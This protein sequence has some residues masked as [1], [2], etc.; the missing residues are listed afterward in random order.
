MPGQ[1]L[2]EYPPHHGRGVRARFEAVG[3]APPCGVRF[4]RV[5]PRI[6]KPVSVRRTAAQVAALL[7]G[8]GGHRG[9]DP[10][11]GPGDLPLGRQPQHRHGVLVVLGREVDP[12]ASLRHPQLDA[13]MLEQRRHRRVLAA[14]ERPLILPDHDC[15]PAAVRISQQGD[16]RG[17]Q[18]A[19]APRHRPALPR[20]KELRHDLPV[21]ADQ[22]PGLLPLPRP[23][24]HRVLP[25]L[26]RHPPVKREPQPAPHRPPGMRAA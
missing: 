4:V 25:V 19:P 18:R 24:R 1:A 7:P 12:P 16:Q 6:S 5:R 11:A 22:C 21:P 3:T 20:I 15:V 17:G 2:G 14:V 13:V 26:G 8:L 9:A 10:D 23:R